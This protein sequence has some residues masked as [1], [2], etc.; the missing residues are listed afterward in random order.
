MTIKGWDAPCTFEMMGESY[1]DEF[2]K[3]VEAVGAKFTI[4]KLNVLGTDYSAG[5]Y[6]IVCA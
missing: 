2:N 3:V 6:D 4:K 1:M 5:M